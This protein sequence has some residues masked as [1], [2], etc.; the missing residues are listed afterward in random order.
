MDAQGSTLVGE[1]VVNR[2]VADEV[3]DIFRQLYEAAACPKD[4]LI[5]DGAGHA[6]AVTK[7]PGLYLDT[8]DRFLE[9]HW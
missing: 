3:V 1:L 2:R 9:T 8:V 6:Q 7:D 5:I 4:I